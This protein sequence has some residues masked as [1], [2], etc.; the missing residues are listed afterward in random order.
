M[1][2]QIERR[3]TD[4]EKQ[5]K[6]IGYRLRAL[7]KPTRPR[8]A[9]VGQRCECGRDVCRAPDCPSHKTDPLGR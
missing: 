5:M 2:D 7:E 1:T 4:I 8:K 3:L 6:E 9:P